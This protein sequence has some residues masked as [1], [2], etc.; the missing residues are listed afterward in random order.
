[1]QYKNERLKM[2]FIFAPSGGTAC[3]HFLSNL[4]GACSQNRSLRFM[5]VKAPLLPAQLTELQELSHLVFLIFRKRLIA[6]VMIRPGNFSCQNA[7]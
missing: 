4:S 1:M 2:F 7:V 5:E 3:V 6:Q